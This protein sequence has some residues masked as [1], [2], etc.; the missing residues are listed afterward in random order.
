MVQTRLSRWYSQIKERPYGERYYGKVIQITSN[1]QH[2]YL[3]GDDGVL[4]CVGVPWLFREEL[5]SVCRDDV[6]CF[7]VGDGGERLFHSVL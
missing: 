6:V 7:V 3:L 5:S 2:L 1:R 4:V